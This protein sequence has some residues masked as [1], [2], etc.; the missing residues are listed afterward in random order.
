M[1]RLLDTANI[2]SL[3]IFVTLI[4]EGRCSSETSVL[5]RATGCNFPEDFILHN[6][7]EVQ[8]PSVISGFFILIYVRYIYIYI[9]INSAVKIIVSYFWGDLN[10]IVPLP[11]SC[12]V[13][14]A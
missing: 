2:P 6:Y 13:T 11:Y 10:L 12:L 1:L 14:Y 4:M 3:P 5:T 9:Y 8:I 7:C